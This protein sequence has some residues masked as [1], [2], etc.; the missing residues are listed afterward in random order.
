MISLLILSL[1]GYCISTDM[2]INNIAINYVNNTSMSNKCS[3]LDNGKNLLRTNK[4]DINNKVNII[5]SK[6]HFN[7]DTNNRDNKD[8]KDN[9]SNYDYDYEYNYEYEFNV[10]N[11]I[12][13]VINNIDKYIKLYYVNNI[14]NGKDFLDIRIINN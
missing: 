3:L 11:Y 7:N 9:V 12:D 5:N 1:L 2:N 14:Y 6:C 4:D 8:N 13:K 10:F